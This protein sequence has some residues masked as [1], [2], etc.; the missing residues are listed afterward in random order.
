MK[1]I[2]LGAA[3]ALL[4]ST[5]LFAKTWTN[6]IGLGFSVPITMVKAKD[7][8]FYDSGDTKANMKLTKE[9]TQLGFNVAGMYL[10][11]HE[12]G[13]TVKG[14]L[15]LGVGYISD[16]W[17]D[18]NFDNK[19]STDPGIG[20]NAFETLGVGYSFVHTDKAVLAATAGLGFQESIY[21]Y[22]IKIGDSE[23]DI[24]DTF[25]TLSLGGDFTAIIRTSDGF[26][27]FGSVYVGWIPT[28]T[29][30]TEAKSGSKKTTEDLDLKGNVV[31]A[32]TI[33]VVWT[34]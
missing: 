26:G 29:Y 10:G 14:S 7:P 15:S 31:I 13:F 21:T 9:K 33:G 27:F 24:T 20:F 1:K 3:V 30:S 17:P 22:N 8:I 25:F 28:G 34:F 11:Y 32:P 5:S 18:V 19:V 2:I 23:T 12:S 6:N 16:Y 4:M